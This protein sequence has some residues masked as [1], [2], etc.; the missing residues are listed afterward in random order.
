MNNLPT[1]VRRRQR[2]RARR[3][4]IRSAK[5]VGTALLAGAILLNCLGSLAEKHGR[6]RLPPNELSFAETPFADSHP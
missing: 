5:E 1:D 2:I 3:R 4:W 6:H